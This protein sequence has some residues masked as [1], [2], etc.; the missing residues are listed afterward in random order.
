MSFK[1]FLVSLQII[2]VF[3]YQNFL[4]YPKFDEDMILL[5]VDESFIEYLKS[6]HITIYIKSSEEIDNKEISQLELFKGGVSYKANIES[7]K[8]IIPTDI[9]VI[10]CYIDFSKISFG[11]YKIKSFTYKS[12]IKSCNAIIEI[13]EVNNKKISEMHITSFYGD[14]KEFQENKN[15]A[16]T[17]NKNIQ[18]PSRLQRMKLV[19]EKNKKYSIGI[20]CSRDDHSSI[21]L[22]CIGDFPLSAGKYQ[23]VDILY[24]NGENDFEFINSKEDLSFDVKEDILQLK[25]VYGE[26]HNEKF[27][28]MG[29]IFKDTVTIKYFSKFFI[30]NT[31]TNKD[32]DIDYK[33]QNDIT[34]TSADE[35][36]IF[37]F[38]NIPI[39]EY[40]VNFVYKQHEHINNAVINIL[41]TEKKD[42]CYDDEGID[43]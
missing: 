34:H 23:I 25:R 12:Q 16:L 3:L 38:S 37:N 13:G 1:L 14:I 30:R 39:G 36:I 6:Q 27:N 2:S 4:S 35:K 9:K 28:I 40:Y 33:F 18:T 10:D 24:Y 26:A 15:F 20:R 8:N 21:S 41:E 29:L 11:K 43:N 17:F 22:N 31:Q 19:N 32:Y 5:K 7:C 42:I